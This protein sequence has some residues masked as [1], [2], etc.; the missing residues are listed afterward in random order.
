[1]SFFTDASIEAIV[2]RNRLKRDV[3]DLEARARLDL[4]AAV[5]ALDTD[6]LIEK[7]AQAI[8]GLLEHEVAATDEEIAAAVLAAI[9][10]LPETT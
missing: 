2:A 7:A 10:L 4:D 6:T 3:A 5:A 9:G 8:Y 1:M